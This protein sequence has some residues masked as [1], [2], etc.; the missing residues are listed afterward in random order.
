MREETVIRETRC[1]SLGPGAERASCV[2]LFVFSILG[3]IWN[4]V[5]RRSSEL[6]NEKRH[7]TTE[8]RVL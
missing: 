4:I 8:I 6:F 1:E 3:R 7:K 2:D 5:H